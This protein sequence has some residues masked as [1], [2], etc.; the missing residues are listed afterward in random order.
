[1]LASELI[2]RLQKEIDDFGDH[3]VQDWTERTVTDVY[4]DID[5]TTEIV[6]EF[7]GDK[8]E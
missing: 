4:I 1:M 6:L 3:E 5:A 2:K 8:D 7:E